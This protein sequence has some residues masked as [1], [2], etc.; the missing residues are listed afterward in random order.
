MKINRKKIKYVLLILVMI[1]LPKNIKASTIM[2]MECAVDDRC[3]D[4]SGGVAIE[5]MSNWHCK[6]TT[7]DFS[8]NWIAK[9]T[10]ENGN[11]S[12][13]LIFS[14]TAMS[15]SDECWL[16]GDFTA[17]KNNCNNNNIY[18]EGYTQLIS[19]GVCPVAIRDEKFCLT[20]SNDPASCKLVPVGQSIPKSQP[21]V[22]DDGIY[23]IYSFTNDE[24][25]DVLIA[26][27]YNPDGKYAFVGGKHKKTFINPYNNGITAHQNKLVNNL[28]G[29]YFKVDSNFDALMVAMKGEINSG[30][31]ICKDKNDCIKNH[32]FKVV[33][34]SRDSNNAIKNTIEKWYESQKENVSSI[35][36]LNESIE[37]QNLINT[38]NE[39]NEK[40][41]SNGNYTFS[42]N[43]SA[44]N[45]ISDLN[46]AYD[47]LKK[48]YDSY[49]FEDYNTGNKTSATSSAMSYVYKNIVG[50]NEIRDL[51]IKDE[52]GY[53][54]NSGF[55]V[56]AIEKSVE[57]TI[58]DISKGDALDIINITRDAKEYTRKFYTT[59]LYLD[60]DSSKLNLSNDQIKQIENL[61]EKYKSLIEDNELNIS[62]VVNCESLLGENLINKINSYLKIIKISIP[63]ILIG[64]GVVDFTKA[65]FAD[66]EDTMKKAQKTFIK[67]LIIAII[68]FLVPTFVSLLLNL[69]N[70]IWPTISPGT[71][72]IYE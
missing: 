30:I 53:H 55:I 21:S 15:F 11:A 28:H 9:I 26:E 38:C 23:I 6:S 69:A 57:D 18:K 50:I 34:D 39:I 65:V 68:I 71:C 56:E 52:S 63:I 3:K 42:Y 54:L 41:G 35:K 51:A 14:D 33:I 17:I 45:L 44:N 4:T 29:E 5:Q 7:T 16:S 25:E 40:L 1:L 2:Y 62:P 20:R 13:R 46:K 70:E 27:G 58:I 66:N 47:G 8:S 32:N 36:G 19:K 59:I 72:G 37:N 43:Y 60:R 61:K 64:L 22:I 24:N 67:R 49:T 31:S 48:V 10:N 12:Y